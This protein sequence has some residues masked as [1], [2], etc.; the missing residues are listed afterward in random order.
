MVENIQKDAGI[1]TERKFSNAESEQKF[2]ENAAVEE[3]LEEI[4]D[5][6]SR[7]CKQQ[8]FTTRLLFTTKN[9]CAY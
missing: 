6:F 3:K 4:A 2:K 9:N 7:D 5:N 1:K 8:W